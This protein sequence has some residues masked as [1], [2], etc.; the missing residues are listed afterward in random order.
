MPGTHIVCIV[1]HVVAVIIETTS[2]VMHFISVATK[3]GFTEY[4]WVQQHN[5]CCMAGRLSANST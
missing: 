5:L 3:V 4:L 1:P 2:A